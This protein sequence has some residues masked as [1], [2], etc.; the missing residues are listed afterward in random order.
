MGKSTTGC[1]LE[2][3]I[4]ACLAAILV[5]R[6]SGSQLLRKVFENKCPCINQVC[7]ALGKKFG[8]NQEV[9]KILA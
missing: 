3:A 5:V 2:I 6:R 9:E 1:N 8:L 7:M 4:A